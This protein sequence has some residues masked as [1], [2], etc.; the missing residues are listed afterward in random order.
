MKKLACLI[1][2]VFILASCGKDNY[3]KDYPQPKI[4]QEDYDAHINYCA[5]TNSK[6]ECEDIPFCDYHSN[7]CPS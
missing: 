3:L 4:Y 7:D 1:Y 5:K 6:E 2:L